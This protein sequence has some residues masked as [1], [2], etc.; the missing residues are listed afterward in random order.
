MQ[1]DQ[2]TEC[3]GQMS[4]HPSAQWCSVCQCELTTDYERDIDKHMPQ[5]T[6]APQI[7]AVARSTD[8][9]TSWAAAKSLTSD[10]IRESQ[11]TVLMSLIHYGPMTD[12]RLV[13]VTPGLSPSGVRTR[14]KELVDMGLVENTGEVTVLVSGRKAIVWAALVEQVE[15]D[16]GGD[17][18]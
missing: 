1:T 6:D 3:E 11:T 13:E 16:L 4:M 10:T 14:R 18:R 8:P 9:G 17:R 7:S 12:T 5:C 15:V 2:P